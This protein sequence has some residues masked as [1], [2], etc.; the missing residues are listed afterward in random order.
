MAKNKASRCSKFTH[1]IAPAPI[2][3]ARLTRSICKHFER[4]QLD[5]HALHFQ[6]L[7]LKPPKQQRTRLHLA[8]HTSWHAKPRYKMQQ[9][10]PAYFRKCQG[11]C[12]QQYL[13][14]VRCWRVLEMV[15][16]LVGMAMGL[17]VLGAA[18]FGVHLQWTHDR[19]ILERI[20]AQQEVRALM[21]T[22]VHDIRRAN[23]HNIAITPTQGPYCPSQFCGA[24]EDFSVAPQQILFSIDRNENGFKEN[25]ECSGFRFNAHQIQTKTSCQPAVWTTLTQVKHL[26]ILSLN[27]RLQCNL[28]TQNP[29]EL[30]RIEIRSQI[31]A[32]KIPLISRREVRLRNSAAQSRNV[33]PNCTET[34]T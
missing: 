11:P 7:P 17:S 12:N 21:D 1:A 30:L 27:L 10:K 26:E 15:N 23:F 25:N 29:A 8:R 19:Q 34:A 28:S 13:P 16:F 32:E 22:L 6:A 24:L 2:T 3:M 4:A 14:F 33:A 31:P 20:H 5:R 9:H 18:V